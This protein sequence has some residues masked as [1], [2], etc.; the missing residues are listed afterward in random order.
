MGDTPDITAARLV[1]ARHECSMHGHDFDILVSGVGVPV[2]I[3][4]S[5]GCGAGPWPV[6]AEP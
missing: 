1:V 3:V 5:R 4:C 2:S 6:G